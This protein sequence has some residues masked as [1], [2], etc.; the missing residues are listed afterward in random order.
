MIVCANG[1]PPSLLFVT[2]TL[3]VPVVTPDQH[4]GH[5]PMNAT[6]TRGTSL[7]PP[8]LEAQ[9]LR[10]LRTV[11]KRHTVIRLGWSWV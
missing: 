4:E 2:H 5:G 8:Q 10:A 7:Q 9:M 11:Q 3:A 6:L 1:E